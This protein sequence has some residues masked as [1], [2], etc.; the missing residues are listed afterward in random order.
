MGKKLPII[1][2]VFVFLAGLPIANFSADLTQF[3]LGWKGS[4]NSES[5]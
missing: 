1:H 3:I 5:W 2:K 4:S